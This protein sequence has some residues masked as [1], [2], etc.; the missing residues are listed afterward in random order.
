MNLSYFSEGNNYLPGQI[1]IES[2]HSDVY[3]IY[4]VQH[5][6]ITVPTRN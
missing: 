5:L 4:I 6:V 3:T 2:I 1:Y